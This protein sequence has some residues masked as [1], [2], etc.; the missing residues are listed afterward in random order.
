M[1]EQKLKIA[2]APAFDQHLC[3]EYM[4]IVCG[5]SYDGPGLFA[6]YTGEAD[7]IKN[8]GQDDSDSMMTLLLGTNPD[9]SLVICTDKRGNIAR[10][11]SGIN[12]HIPQAFQLSNDSSC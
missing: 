5:S 3:L 4:V 11:I 6:E 2:F 8:R 12:N 7:Y 1:L 10:F 9:E